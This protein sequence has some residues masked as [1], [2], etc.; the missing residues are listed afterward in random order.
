MLKFP[1]QIVLGSQSPRRKELL[2]LMNIDFRVEVQEVEESYPKSSFRR[3][4]CEPNTI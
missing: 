1:F 3:G 2:S 4:D